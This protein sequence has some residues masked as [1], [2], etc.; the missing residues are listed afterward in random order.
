M[1]SSFGYIYVFIIVC[2]I[3]C[4]RTSNETKS[5]TL[6]NSNISED[7]DSSSGSDSLD[8]IKFIKDFALDR[9]DT[10]IVGDVNGDR[11][12]D[13]AIIEPATFI[14]RD[15]KVDS[16]Y[17]NISFTTDIPVIRHYNGF[18]GLIAN[19]GDLDGNKTDELIYYPDWFIGN[20]ASIYI[21]G[22]R[23]GEWKLF[24]DGSQRRD[25]IFETK[26]PIKYL[27]SRVEKIDNNSFKL[28]EITMNENAEF[29]DSTSIV[30]IH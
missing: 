10:F 21:Y 6:V 14:Y 1:N 29:I 11:K 16:Q 7:V 3:G 23:D 30:F 19:V 17:V 28:T 9:A 4:T 25:I 12:V 8:V 2:S 18:H 5:K 27:Q 22:L 26:D 20:M 24:A 13:K 15:G